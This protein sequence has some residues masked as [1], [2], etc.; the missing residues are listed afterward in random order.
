MTESYGYDKTPTPPRDYDVNKVPAEIR[1]RTE[2]V[3]SKFTGEDVAEAYRQAGDVAGI[4]AGEAKR[5]AEQTQYRQDAV[6]DFNTQ[7]IQEMTDKDVISAPE[8]IEARD[9]NLTLADRLDRD[10]GIVES[11]IT[12]NISQIEIGVEFFG[13]VGDGVTDDSQAF[14]DGFDYVTDNHLTLSTKRG[15]TY[16]VDDIIINNK[17]NFG[18]NSKGVL[19]RPDNLAQP[20]SPGTA[21]KTLSFLNCSNFY[22]SEVSLDGNHFN[23]HCFV[24]PSEGG[25]TPTTG[26]NQG[27][28]YQEWRHSLVF[29][30]C[31]EF[32]VDYINILNPSGDG[33]LLTGESKNIVIG[34]I[35]GKSVDSSGIPVDLGRNLLS[36]TDGTSVLKI[37]SIISLN[38]GHYY[39]PGGVDIEPNDIGASVHDVF[40]NYIYVLTGGTGGVALFDNYNKNAIENITINT[41]YS[42]NY[43]ETTS[44]PLLIAGANNVVIHNA[45]TIER[46]MQGYSTQIGR[47]KNTSNVYLPNLIAEGGMLGIFLSGDVATNIDI[48]V[49]FRNTKDNMIHFAGKNDGIKVNIKGGNFYSQD[50]V[51]RVI[52]VSPESEYLK[53]SH[54]SG[55][56]AQQTTGGGK[57]LFLLGGFTGIVENIIFENLIATGW[58]DRAREL[59]STAFG[60]QLS[61]V[62]GITIENC[63]GI[64][65]VYN[66]Q[67]AKFNVVKGMYIKNL[68]PDVLTDSTGEYVIKGWVIRASGQYILEG[69]PIEDRVYFTP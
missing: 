41:L 23:N 54:F 45:H 60:Y 49:E 43:R 3:K 52:Y 15:K 66:L 48:S 25:L 58:I 57:I 37:N 10:L 69:L 22:I 50:N 59:D 12:T 36:I 62:S 31:S 55:S 40:I 46:S 8:I 39:M 20:Q 9:G 26:Y 1:K 32:Q 68:S 4:Y 19:K 34:D 56:I 14:R 28:Y 5:I 16:M 21:T 27:G 2:W 63:L 7:V 61:R 30:G 24:G 65:S 17:H 33:V 47:F 6:E 67:N 29:S 51:N 13:A 18:F 38:I 44:Y 11:N 42:E 53:N 64:T 35:F